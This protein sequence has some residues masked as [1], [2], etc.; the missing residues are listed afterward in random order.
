LFNGLATKR[1]ITQKDIELSNSQLQ[2]DLL[3]QQSRMQ[4]E[5]ARNQRNVAN[6]TV[7][8]TV[9]HMNLAQSIYDQTL[10]Q[11]KHGTATLTDILMADNALQEAQ[12]AYLTAVVDYLKA[13]LELKKQTGNIL[14]DKP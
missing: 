13:D 9:A 7:A 2:T 6:R 5:N 1:R 4:T 10:L 12:Q 11:Q 8:N 14:N 3:V